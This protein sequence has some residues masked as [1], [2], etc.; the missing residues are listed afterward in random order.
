MIWTCQK[1]GTSQNTKKV[2]EKDPRADHKHGGYTK[3][4][5]TQKEEGSTGGR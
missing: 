1:N 3:L 4:R 5:D 2:T